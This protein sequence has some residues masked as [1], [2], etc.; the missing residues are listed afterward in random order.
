M[1]KNV[2]HEK[3][4]DLLKYWP[5]QI[6]LMFLVLFIIIGC[7]H[8]QE[9]MYLEYDTSFIADGSFVNINRDNTWFG[10]IVEKNNVSGKLKKYYYKGEIKK[11]NELIVTGGDTY[12]EIPRVGFM[13]KGSILGEIVNNKIHSGELTLKKLTKVE[14]ENVKNMKNMERAKRKEELKKEQARKKEEQERRAKELYPFVDLGLPSG[15]LWKNE[16]EEGYY[17]YWEAVKKYGNM[18]PTK[19][20]YQ[21]ILDVCKC[22]DHTLYTGPNGNSIELAPCGYMYPPYVG[23]EVHYGWASLWSSSRATPDD[24]AWGFDGCLERE[25]CRMRFQ[26]RLVKK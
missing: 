20:Q 23:S 9:G 18:L 11:S 21:E 5:K 13:D 16:N 10:T 2:L 3:L 7:S 14:M 4:F 12:R 1:M 25:S 26:V 15:T 6:A 19:E 22:S 17:S 24:Y 8:K